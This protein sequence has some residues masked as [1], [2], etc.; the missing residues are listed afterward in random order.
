MPRD[1]RV[2]LKIGELH[3]KRGDNKESAATLLRV[4]EAYSNDGFFL[5]AAAVYKQ[6]LKLNPALLDVNLRLAELYQQHGLKS[7]AMQQYQLVAAAYEKLGNSGASLN[8]Y[9]KLVD[10]EPDNAASRVRLAEAF[11]KEG[12]NQEAIAELGKVAAQL[13]QSGRNEEFIK[14][15]ERLLSLDPQN[16]PLIR[17]LAN[18][19]LQRGETKRALAR[20]QTCF[21][22]NPRD[23]DTL[24]LLAQTFL[25]LGQQVKTISVYKELARIYGERGRGE[26]EQATWRR[27]LSLAPRDPD[28]LAATGQAAPVLEA[29]F[30][31]ARE[32]TEP[33]EPSTVVAPVPAARAPKGEGRQAEVQKLLTEADVYLKYGLREKAAAHLRRILAA[34]PESV[35]AHQKAKEL[36]LLT[37]NTTGAADELVQCAQISLNEGNQPQAKVFLEQL[38]ELSP[39]HPEL[40]RMQRLIGEVADLPELG[41][42]E[43][44]LLEALPDEDELALVEA[45]EEPALAVVEGDETLIDPLEDELESSLVDEAVLVEGDETLDPGEPETAPEAMPEAAILLLGFLPDEPPGEEA[46]VEDSTEM[47][48]AALAAVGFESPGD[49]PPA[50]ALDEFL[51]ASEE[52]SPPLPAVAPAR[53]SRTLSGSRVLIPAPPPLCRKSRPP[54]GSNSPPQPED[55]PAGAGRARV[56]SRPRLGGGSG[57]SAGGIAIGAY[58]A[59]GPPRE[60]RRARPEAGRAA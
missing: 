9:K 8:L 15:A 24:I 13:K 4:A 17:E 51:G 30:E 37:G 6:V 26:E 10:L 42:D 34:A 22:V 57:G 35:A 48:R 60:A 32:R 33:R 45:E 21:K 56:L 19:Y 31:E 59:P 14:V 1:I 25:D 55:D 11:S 16:L 54:P 7:D 36:H 47:D 44:T 2:L 5:K 46:L 27:I 20:L 50:D 41:E 40:A 53:F 39:N 49:P 58:L 28:A 18:I 43:A 12:M 29:E 3:Q 52:P 38:R 23:I